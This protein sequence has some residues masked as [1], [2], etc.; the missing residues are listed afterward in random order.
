MKKEMQ[1]SCV[2]NE[3][4]ASRI[5]VTGLQRNGRAALPV[6]MTARDLPP[7]W[8]EV[9][10]GLVNTLKGVAP[11]EWAAVFITAELIDLP[12]PED[13]PE[14]T[15][16]QPAVELKIRRL[17]DDKTTAPPLELVMEDAAAVAFFNA[18][19]SESVEA[20]REYF[21]LP[22]ETLTNE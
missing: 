21:G 1:I 14:G 4:D 2:P 3:W 5:T 12:I 13:A 10:H 9:W 16:Q 22:E 19:T 11:G 17:W 8:L 15:E 20:A 6:T 7:E 18:L